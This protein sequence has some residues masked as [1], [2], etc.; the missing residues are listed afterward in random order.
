MLEFPNKNKQKNL[1]SHWCRVLAPQELDF[2][3]P[4]SSSYSRQRSHEWQLQVPKE[5]RRISLGNNFCIQGGPLV[6]N[7]SLPLQ[8]NLYD[9][10]SCTLCSSQSE[11]FILFVP[12]DHPAF[13]QTSLSLEY[14]PGIFELFISISLILPGLQDAAHMLPPDILPDLWK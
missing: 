4:V 5:D 3:E 13:A 12:G 2:L 8:F 14:L 1:S 11:L 6:F 9:V 10:L 7:L